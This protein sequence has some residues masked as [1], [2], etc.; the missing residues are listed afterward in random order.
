[1]YLLM[2]VEP[3][4]KHG[5]SPKDHSPPADGCGWVWLLSSRADLGIHALGWDGVLPGLMLCWP[6][7]GQ[8]SSWS[9][10]QLS[11]A[12]L[13]T[14]PSRW[15]ILFHFYFSF[16]INQYVHFKL[17][18]LSS[19]LLRCPADPAVVWKALFSLPLNASFSHLHLCESVCAHCS[20]LI[21][22]SRLHFKC[23]ASFLKCG[24]AKLYD[25][26]R[27]LYKSDINVPW[28]YMVWATIMN[29][30]TSSSF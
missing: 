9:C 12:A 7:A 19:S 8:H 21:S 6:R 2:G 30:V 27:F 10:W 11:Q 29:F 25:K 15:P 14:E 28:K 3:A 17:M 22:V 4:T 5:Q 16:Y 23:C 26:G 20:L 18:L 1:M 24:I 13:L